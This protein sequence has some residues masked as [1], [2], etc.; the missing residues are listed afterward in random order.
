MEKIVKKP[1]FIVLLA[2][3]VFYILNMS[4]S[5]EIVQEKLNDKNVLIELFINAE[6]TICPKAAFCL[7]D[8]AWSYESGKVILVEEHIWGDGYDSPET[9]ERYNWYVEDGVK[10]TPD[11]FFN[12]L[13]ERVQGLC[14]DCDDIEKHYLYC[15]SIIE[16]ELAKT[17]PI[18]LI[19]EKSYF[20]NKIIIQGRLENIS[21]ELL[22]NLIIGGII[23]FE[24]EES[25]LFYLVK[26]VFDSQDIYQL[27][28]L[29]EKKFNFVSK[30]ELT[31][32]DDNDNADK[33]HS[34]IFIQDKFNKEIL[35][36]LLIK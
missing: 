3:F 15:Q 5:S 17:S 12:G 23:Y 22:Q 18:D 13:S 26:D 28:P 21:H 10:G 7:E 16:K 4:V 9:N 20:G 25:E 31:K 32:N 6:C 14:C 33:Y 24:G 30:I 29:E 34:V 19:A 1:I 11:I 27:A 36:S 2:L 8:L 35:Q